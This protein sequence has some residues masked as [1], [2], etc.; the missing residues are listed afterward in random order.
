MTNTE[1]ITSVRA[2]LVREDGGILVVQRHLGCDYNPGLWEVPGGQLETGE[3]L[4]EGVVREFNQETGLMLDPLSLGAPRLVMERTIPDGKHEGKFTRTF[5]FVALG[6]TGQLEV[7]SKKCM[8]YR[9]SGR[10]VLAR[11]QT[12]TT[13]TKQLLQNL[14]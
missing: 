11:R 13:V 1:T 10:T 5:G 6:A 4:A 7:D 12:V 3:T 9:W 8:G 2:A 14:F